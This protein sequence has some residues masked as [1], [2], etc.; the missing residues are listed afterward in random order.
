MSLCTCP[1]EGDS[2][3]VLLE[4][5]DLSRVIS[6]TCPDCGEYVL[7]PTDPAAMDGLHAAGLLVT[8]TRR[9]EPDDEGG[10]YA[11]HDLSEPSA[12][13]LEQPENPSARVGPREFAWHTIRRYIG[14]EW[15][16]D[17][18]AE[19]IEETHAEECGQLPTG[20]VCWFT[21]APHDFWW[22]RGLGT[23]R[24]RLVEHVVGDHNGEFS[25][26]QTEMEIHTW[27]SALN[28]WLDEDGKV[29]DE[30]D[31]GGFR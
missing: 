21:H 23:W 20:A 30:A 11:W 14:E 19:L 6:V 22:P 2:R 3:P 28:V 27:D 12:E 31:G 29:V 16:T 10:E 25:D 13:L 18:P 4:I 7:D 17:G 1:V 8:M 24:I 9:T 5:G 26:V 15:F